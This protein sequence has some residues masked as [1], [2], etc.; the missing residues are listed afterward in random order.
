MNVDGKFRKDIRLALVSA[1]P[2]LSDLRILVEDVLGVPLQN[3]SL[4]NNLPA[5]VFDL[6]AWAQARGRLAELV[7]GAASE[8]QADARLREI[9]D[10]FRF[11]EAA[12]GENERIVLQ[13][14]PFENAG[15]WL[16]RLGRIRRGV[17]RVEPQPEAESV[18]GYASG[19]LVA[20]D[21]MMTNFH[22]IAD[23]VAKK[24]KTVVRFD[25]E[26]GVDGKTT[27][28][29]QCG[30]ASEWLL[31]SSPIDQLDYALVRLSEPA[32]DDAVADTKRGVLK[33]E[34]HDFAANE[35]IIVLQH[36]EAKPLKLAFGTVNDPCDGARVTY[37][38]NTEGGSSGSPCLSSALQVVAI[39]HWGGPNHNRGIRMA[40]ILQHLESLGLNALIG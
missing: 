15:Q 37:S 32:G 2:E 26:V 20:S 10:H 11:A 39:H 6:I 21:V 5:I 18:R 35:P 31:A 36:P 16:E 19:F 24:N 25:Y 40:A 33:L 8:R 4:G 28:G 3:I 30:L 13:S 17:C 38:A 34:A 14:V 29:R 22:V 1:F 23:L 9:A 12:A 7:I 27:A